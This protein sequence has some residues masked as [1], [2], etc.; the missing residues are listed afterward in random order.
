MRKL[1][2]LYTREEISFLLAAQQIDLYNR[3]HGDTTHITFYFLNTNAIL[4][5]FYL[6]LRKPNNFPVTFEREKMFFIE[7][8]G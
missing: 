7:I 4:N 3:L 2:V 1:N 5:N 6:I 8:I